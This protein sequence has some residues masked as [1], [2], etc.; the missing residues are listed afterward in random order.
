MIHLYCPKFCGLSQTAFV[1][2]FS[3][4]LFL[5]CGS[6]A[7]QSFHLIFSCLL[8][9]TEMNELHYLFCWDRRKWKR[10]APDLSV[11]D[12]EKSFP[13]SP[14]VCIMCYRPKYVSCLLLAV[15]N[16][17]VM[18]INQTHVYQSKFCFITK[19]WEEWL[20]RLLDFQ[21]IV[22]VSKLLSNEVGNVYH[23]CLVL[24][25][26]TTNMSQWKLEDFGRCFKG[27]EGEICSK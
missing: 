21:A 26:R 9:R 7:N 19:T 23:F 8:G 17:I 13:A 27:I 22:Y 1:P 11:P 5:S 25:Q 24:G 2:S 10:L 20:S 18:D 3:P 14:K 6:F 4:F 15:I 16:I 12:K